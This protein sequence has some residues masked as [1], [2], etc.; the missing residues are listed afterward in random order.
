MTTDRI[1]CG[2]SDLLQL[3]FRIRG[4]KYLGFC[5]RW[6][7]WRDDALAHLYGH[8]KA[9][10]DLCSQHS[11]SEL[12]SPRSFYLCWLWRCIQRTGIAFVVTHITLARVFVL[13]P[14]QLPDKADILL[15]ATRW[16]VL[17]HT[18]LGMK[19]CAVSLSSC[20]RC[21]PQESCDHFKVYVVGSTQRYAMLLEIKPSKTLFFISQVLWPRYSLRA[22][23]SIHGWKRTEDRWDRRKSKIGQEGDIPLRCACVLTGWRRVEVFACRTLE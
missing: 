11:A 15:R 12:K 16:A 4:Q 13:L 6:L 10:F 14:K 21:G 23:Q 22:V 5:L 2:T 3:A 7:W 19:L 17:N 1:G 8:G 20:K 9:N 18:M